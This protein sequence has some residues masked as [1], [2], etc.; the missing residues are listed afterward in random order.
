MPTCIEI[1]AVG[2]DGPTTVSVSF[3]QAIIL[4]G[5]PQYA[6]G[7]PTVL[8][9]EATLVTPTLV[10]LTYATAATG[11]LV[12]PYRD[13]A[14]RNATGGFV[15]AGSHELDAQAAQAEA[16]AFSPVTFKKAA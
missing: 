9:T 15:T 7:G 1:T 3:D 6:A 12:V 16:Q 2:L 14:V 4:T 8:P 13:P 11:S 5:I 10:I